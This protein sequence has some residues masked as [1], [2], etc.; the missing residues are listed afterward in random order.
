MT[1]I[2]GVI[3]KQ[4]FRTTNGKFFGIMASD[5]M[6]GNMKIQGIRYGFTAYGR[7]KYRYLD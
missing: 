5:G 1:Y 4:C 6:N 3:L 7:N 2:T